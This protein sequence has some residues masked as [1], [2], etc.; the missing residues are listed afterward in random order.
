MKSRGWAKL[1]LLLTAVLTAAGLV[2]TAVSGYLAT[3]EASDSVVRA[4]A[5][6]LLFAAR[7]TLIH[8]RGQLQETMREF[9]EETAN[10]GLRYAAVTT[11]FG[12]VLA[13]A[14][15]PA[16]PLAPQSFI[17]IGR[18]P[19][20]VHP[21]G[22]GRCYRVVTRLAGSDVGRRWSEA[23]ETSL[24]QRPAA[25][26]LE[27]EPQVTTRM[28]A[29][30]RSTLAGVTVAAILL[31]GA[32]LLFWRM[33][34]KQSRIEAQ[35]T[36]DRQ[37]RV[38]GEMSAVL[39]HEIRNPLTALKG[40]AQLLVER[41]PEGST[42]QGASTIVREAIRMEEL[43]AHILAFARTGTVDLSPEDPLLVVRGAAESV[44][45][46]RVVVKGP[47]DLPAW[48]LDRVRIEQALANLIR[49]AVQASPENVAVEVAVSVS[50]RALIIEVRDHGE[51]IAPDQI[52]RIFEPFHTTRT[53]GTGLG[54]TVA[55]RVVEGHRG[56]IEATNHPDGGAVFRVELPRAE[57]RT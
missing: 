46:D 39:G 50:D 56:R 35:L 3:I 44:A 57:V 20:Q 10:Q 30:A 37:L 40:H 33:S 7:R 38:L 43:V 15:T 53:R 14:G 55:R 12:E 32:A 1:G 49:N 23:L 45:D 34:V 5:I 4:W 17:A 47:P 28:V 21:I 41:L 8:A 25:V 48:P 42:R 13:S 22:D 18:W 11:R 16:E 54:L 9:M 51:G 27:F 6:D 24:G 2:G 36:E 31:M 52:E 19:P 29:R 26:V